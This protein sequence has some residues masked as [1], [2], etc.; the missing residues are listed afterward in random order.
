MRPRYERESLKTAFSLLG[1]GQVSLTKACLVVGPEVDC[2]DARTVLREIGR[3]FDPSR[4]AFIIPNT[5][6]DTLDFTGPKMNAGSK[7]VMDLTGPHV[8]RP[9][10]GTLPDLAG[11]YD[12]VDRQKFVAESVLL[13]RLK[14]GRAGRP[15]LEQ[16]LADPSLASMPLVVVV[17][18]DVDLEDPVSWL[19]GWFTRFDPQ[20]DVLFARTTL[21]GAVAVHEGV[22]CVDATWKQGYPEPLEMPEE[23]VKRVD[24]RWRDYGFGSPLA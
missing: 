1:E 9:S 22:M 15:V 2:R 10:F 7:L 16:L 24:S 20:R 6:A 18:S 8:E 13:V 4:D 19:W 12:A 3:R 5:S 11:R 14:A 23:I 21:R 17:S